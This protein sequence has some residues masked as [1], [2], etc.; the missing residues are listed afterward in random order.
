MATDTYY[1]I[2]EYSVP[3]ATSSVTLSGFDSGYTDLDLIINSKL[4]TTAVAEVL[5]TLNGVSSTGSNYSTSRIYALTGNNKGADRLT[6]GFVGDVSGSPS[7]HV[8]RFLNYANTFGKKSFI[9]R[10]GIVNSAVV[11]AVS[12]FDSTSAITSITISASSG[13]FAVGSTFSLMGIKA[14]STVATTKANGGDIYSDADY[15]Y[16]VFGR[17]GTFTPL[18]SLTADILVVAGGGGGGAGQAGQHYSGGGGAGG[19]LTFA[20][21]S[22]SATSYTVTVGAGGA[23]GNGPAVANG[24]NGSNSRFGALT[25]CIGGGGGGSSSNTGNAGGSGGGGGGINNASP[26]GGA[27]TAGQGFAGGQGIQAYNGGGG[28][29]AGAVGYAGVAAIGGGAGGIG[30]TSSLI[31]AM[32]R[33]TGQGDVR[34]GNVYFAG[35]GSAADSAQDNALNPAFGGGGSSMYAGY[36]FVGQGLPATGGGGAGGT[37]SGSSFGE[38]GG[39]G[40]SGIVI[41]R[42]AKV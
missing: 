12:S 32:G 40:G 26:A 18:Q 35:G 21:Q 25:E 3:T 37:A 22:L 5:V 28:G 11:I 24:S 27:G 1:A 17:T 31:N 23:G 16:H 42:Y 15:F 10:G 14:E 20:S 29:G 19:L 33:A 4:S 38:D 30:A 39:Q 6:R 41:V 34:Q 9:S 8:I 36:S 7:I 2:S 13:Q